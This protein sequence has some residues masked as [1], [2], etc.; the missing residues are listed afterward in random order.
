LFFGLEISPA[1]LPPWRPLAIGLGLGIG[2]AVTKVITGYWTALRA[3]VDRQGRWR[4]G[5][6]L[7]A[8]G[9]FSIIIDGLGV[10]KAGGIEPQPE[11]YSDM[12][13]VDQQPGSLRSATAGGGVSSDRPRGDRPR[14]QRQPAF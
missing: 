6:A 11:R 1:S 13:V 3:G 9:E 5:V 14:A 12:R 4:A 10:A 7:V 8:R 2:T